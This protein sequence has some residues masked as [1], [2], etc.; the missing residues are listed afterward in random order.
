[1]MIDSIKLIWSCI[2]KKRLL[3]I[4]T[5][6]LGYFGKLSLDYFLREEPFKLSEQALRALLGSA[7]LLLAYYL[8]A[9]F[10]FSI[11]VVSELSKS[12]HTTSL[13]SATDGQS[14]AP[15]KALPDSKVVIGTLAKEFLSADIQAK[16]VLEENATPDVQNFLRR[17]SMGHP[18]CPKC[19]RPLDDIAADWRSLDT[20]PV[21]YYCTN[22]RN[23]SPGHY[24][25][26][27][28]NGQALV[29]RDFEKYWK[30]YQTKIDE[31][32]NARR[33]EFTA[34]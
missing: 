8:F 1:M 19:L 32:T 11:K 17:I 20:S 18:Y 3:S 6:I 30:I 25:N 4:V 14:P 5:F 29:R 26:L 28:K 33:N 27:L 7:V 31:L 23:S 9:F 24:D 16:I 22:C 13:K 12:A 15:K 2:P 21:G 34:G 10:Y